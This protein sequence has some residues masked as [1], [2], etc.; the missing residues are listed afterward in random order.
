MFRN[1]SW[2]IIG[3]F[4][5]NLKDFAVSFHKPIAVAELSK[6]RTV[7]SRSNT[8]I[9]GSNPTEAWMFVCVFCVRFFCFYSLK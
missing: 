5:E 7:F 9:V 6:A 2:W 8:A 3:E 4:F 1:I